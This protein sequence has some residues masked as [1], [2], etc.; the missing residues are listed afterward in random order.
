[1]QQ[2]D[3]ETTSSK[4][5]VSGLK[6]INYIGRRKVCINFQTDTDLLNMVVYRYRNSLYLKDKGVSLKLPEY[7]SILTKR[8][9]LL[10]YV[11]IVY[12]WRIVIDKT[13]VH[14]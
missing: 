14:R 8:V 6:W 3:I 5:E 1:M 13:T 10:S 4:E 7:Q 2:L 12:K 11:D 9:Y